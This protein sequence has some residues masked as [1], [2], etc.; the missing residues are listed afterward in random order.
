MTIWSNW[1]L[2]HQQVAERRQVAV[3][4]WAR[5]RHRACHW[6]GL[7]MIEL[8]CRLAQPEL[9]RPAPPRI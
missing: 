5:P 4:Q 7:R 3:R 6:L 8:G 1:E 9:V 2:A